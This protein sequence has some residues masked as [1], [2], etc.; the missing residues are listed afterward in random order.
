MKENILSKI[1]KKKLEKKEKI[2]N[3]AY[4]LFIEKGV[5]NTSIQE[6]VDAAGIAK[7]TFYLYFKDKYDL[8]TELIASKSKELF[9]EA[10]AKMY[11]EKID[12]FSEE[13]IFVI[14]YIIDYL[15]GDKAL[16]NFIS[17]DLSL[18][19]Y[20][21]KYSYLIE[22][23]EIGVYDVFMEGIKKNKIKL[24][25]PEVTLFMIIELVS[26]TC[27][28]SITQNYPLPIEEYK[29]FLHNAIKA[30]INT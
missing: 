15:V 17:K 3:S 9:E 26:S 25:N 28:T 5:N 27:F 2:L 6:I 19:I 12:D 13:L 4:K 30:L 7:G 29:P 10:I 1:K 8:E 16:L 20:A 22:N 24:K 14:D 21:G 18:G 23:D 11:K